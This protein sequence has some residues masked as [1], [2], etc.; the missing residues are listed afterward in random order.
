VTISFFQK[1]IRYWHKRT[2]INDRQSTGN[3][4]WFGGEYANVQTLQIAE[5]AAMKVR[6]KKVGSTKFTSQ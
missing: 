3:D 5:A 4:G 1:H 2:G 6:R